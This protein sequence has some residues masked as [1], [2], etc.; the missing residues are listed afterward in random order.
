MRIVWSVPVRGEPL[1]SS[2]GDLVR[3][4]HLIAGLRQ[5]GYEV[6]VVAAASDAAAEFTVSAYR[7]LARRL[8]PSKAALVLRDLGRWLHGR[9]HGQRVLAEA[10]RFG[11]E[12]IVETQVNYSISGILAAH[13][14]GLPLVLDDCAPT[15]EEEALG[16]GLP[17]LAQRILRQQLSAAARATVPSRA[18]RDRFL[19]EGVP[20]G[21]LL[22]VPNGVD[23]AAFTDRRAELRTRFGVD[24]RCVLGFVGSFQPWHGV[25]L[26]VKAMAELRDRLPLH[27][28]LIG[29]GPRRPL[30]AA[31]VQRLGLADQVTFLGSV[32]STEVPSLLSMLD[33]GTL[34]AANDYSHPMKLLEYGAA[35]L[36]SIAPDVP[37]VREVLQEG[38][39]G[40]LFPLGDEQA[41]GDRIGRL[42]TNPALRLQLGSEARGRILAEAAWSN[43]ATLLAEAFEAHRS[44]ALVRR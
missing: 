41:L 16:A 10:K 39:T 36:P 18:L 35:G 3:A 24:K 23:P 27:L 15:E 7:N 31:A 38:S 11:A 33:V 19:A 22:V 34:P 37:P 44:P 1:S 8:L 13:A 32:D 25:E 2:R 4:R 43:R 6:Q 29:D 20:A 12:M 30:V 40:L 5:R 14:S 42:A 9:A 26:L 17:A 28:M 21:K